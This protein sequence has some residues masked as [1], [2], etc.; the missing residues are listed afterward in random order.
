MQHE[1]VASST[2]NLVDKMDDS[3]A[4]IQHLQT[5]TTFQ[6]LD[7]ARDLAPAIES[8]HN[9]DVSV[10]LF[11]GSWHELYGDANDADRCFDRAFELDPKHPGAI[12]AKAIGYIESGRP[13]DAEPLLEKLQ[14]PSPDY[15]PGMFFRL[16][17]GFQE[18]NQHDV[19]LK[20]FKQLAIDT[21]HLKYTKEFRQAV[22]VSE[23][24]SGAKSNIVPRKPLMNRT[25]VLFGLIAFLV[26]GGLFARNY[27]AANHR[28]LFVVNGLDQALVVK[29]DE[30]SEFVIP[31]AQHFASSISEGSHQVVVVSPEAH[32]GT[33]TFSVASNIRERFIQ[34]PAFVL[35]PTESGI[36]YW[37][38]T[39][40]RVVPRDDNEYQH[41]FGQLISKFKHVDYPFSSFPTT[42]EINS[43]NSAI[44][45][46]RIGFEPLT[47]NSVLQAVMYEPSA[48]QFQILED[49][50]ESKNGQR[51]FYSAYTGLCIIRQQPDKAKRFLEPKLS[52][53]PVDLELHQ[54]Y[55]SFMEI[56]GLQDE[57]KETYVRLLTDNPRNA[58]Y[59]FLRGRAETDVETSNKFYRQS[60]EINPQAPGPYFALGY[61]NWITG[62]FESAVEPIRKAIGL[63]ADDEETIRILK[64]ALAA[65]GDFA[66]LQ[67]LIE[68]HPKTA[69]EFMET[70]GML[71]AAGQQH[72]FGKVQQRLLLQ[73]PDPDDKELATYFGHYLKQ[74]YLAIGALTDISKRPIDKRKDN[75]SYNSQVY[76]FIYNLET[77]KTSA[78][79]KAFEELEDDNTEYQMLLGIA[80][81]NDDKKVQAKK[82]LD[83][84]IELLESYGGVDAEMATLLRASE[85]RE[86]APHEINQIMMEPQSKR[87]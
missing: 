52:Q 77:M 75:F 84:T 71:F 55:Q 58:A 73:Y 6:Q 3:S 79:K 49:L 66:Q 38:K 47:P 13:A 87:V 76:W 43:D 83:E 40:Y 81:L 12:R 2:G 70:T 48:R 80:F 14:L 35:D 25:V 32:K 36:V 22:R 5:L 28:Q 29:I 7:E 51:N 11:L 59:V 20:H 16:A 15:D 24:Q 26:A 56:M 72:E 57:M 62:D 19:A 34:T 9:S 8:T 54:A 78:A 50:I 69:A 46:T 68:M 42:I 23:K 10:Q 65:T 33:K 86:I 39:Y 60:I 74:S 1:A 53:L 21:P 44:P 67:T 30:G 17:L 61:N 41:R 82:Y 37:E 64:Q 4:A 31:P 18:E 85:N 45:K 63:G 27:W